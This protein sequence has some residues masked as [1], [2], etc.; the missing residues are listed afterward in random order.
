MLWFL[1]KSSNHLLF[2]RLYVAGDGNPGCFGFCT[3]KHGMLESENPMVMFHGHVRLRIDTQTWKS[4]K[5]TNMSKICPKH[6][7]SSPSSPSSP[8]SKICQL[9]PVSKWWSSFLH[10]CFLALQVTPNRAFCFLHELQPTT[11][12]TITAPTATKCNQ[13]HKLFCLR[14]RYTCT[15][16]PILRCRHYWPDI[17][18][19]ASIL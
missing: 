5:D 3:A 15:T 19:D 4:S 9:F 1:V 7:Q 12:E 17:S 2:G 14:I 6:I 18:H 10:Q 8:S 11:I 13:H 16:V